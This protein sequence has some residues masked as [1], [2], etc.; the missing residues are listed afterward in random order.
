MS[1][2]LLAQGQPDANHRAARIDEAHR[3]TERRTEL[4]FCHLGLGRQALLRGVVEHVKHV[5]QQF[6]SSTATE[7]CSPR[8]THIEQ[9]L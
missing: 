6:D 5:Q 2:R 7:R 4:G 1:G 3:L 9:G 8:Q